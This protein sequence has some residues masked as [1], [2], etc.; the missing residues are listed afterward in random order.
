MD[1]Y[2]TGLIAISVSK[3]MS[4]DLCPYPCKEKENSSYFKCEM[5]WKR[6]LDLIA[7]GNKEKKDN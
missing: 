7:Y 3:T 6:I 1:R 2:D 5:H 4:C